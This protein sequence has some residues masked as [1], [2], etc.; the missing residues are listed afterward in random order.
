MDLKNNVD[1][2]RNYL[3]NNIDKRIIKINTKV[4]DFME[5]SSL[6]EIEKNTIN[7]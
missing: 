6:K 7:N 1:D 3:K 4:N 2:Q 5:Y